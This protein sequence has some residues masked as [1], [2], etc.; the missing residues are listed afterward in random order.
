MKNNKSVYI[1]I[2][3]II[4][5]II[6]YAIFF[7]NDTSQSN[8]VLVLKANDTNTTSK[9]NDRNANL[10]EEEYNTLK[11]KRTTDKVNLKIKEDTLTNTG[12]TVII[13]DTNELPY[14]YGEAYKIQKLENN[15]W[16]DIKTKDG[17]VFNDLAYN[18]DKNGKL[19]MQINW[20][21]LYGSLKSGEYKLSKEIGDY[22]NPE[23]I[24]V[25]FEIK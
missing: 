15:E 18:T 2:A 16:K 13:T 12:T 6:L 9:I 10:T 24:S 17:Y 4:I 5:G 11:E 1:A 23:I 21:D 22:D 8:N 14:S 7:R 19:E 25:E 3:L 20:N